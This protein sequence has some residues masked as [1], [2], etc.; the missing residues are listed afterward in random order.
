MENED[1]T[2]SF[3]RPSANLYKMAAMIGAGI[4]EG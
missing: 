2:G 1:V 4:A 3:N